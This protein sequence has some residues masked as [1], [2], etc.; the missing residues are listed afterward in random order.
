LIWVKYSDKL[1]PIN[2]CLL[3]RKLFITPHIKMNG[4]AR[5]DFMY[6]Y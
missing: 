3:I 4:T 1:L 6:D 2:C 5:G